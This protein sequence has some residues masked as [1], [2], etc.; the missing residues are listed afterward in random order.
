MAGRFPKN[1]DLNVEQICQVGIGGFLFHASFSQLCCS[2]WTGG[3]RGGKSKPSYR[4]QA[5][6]HK[7]LRS[8]GSKQSCDGGLKE[9]VGFPPKNG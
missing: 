6:D 5:T 9:I 1:S 2:I 3:I 8:P 7:S 4:G